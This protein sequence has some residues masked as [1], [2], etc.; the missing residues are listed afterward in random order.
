[1]SNFVKSSIPSNRFNHYHVL[2][3]TSFGVFP[4]EVGQDVEGAVEWIDDT[5]FQCEEGFAV[6]AVS[7]YTLA[8]LTTKEW[9]RINL[10]SACIEGKSPAYVGDFSDEVWDRLAAQLIP[11]YL[12]MPETKEVEAVV[13][14]ASYQHW[15]DRDA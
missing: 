3:V 6:R 7:R 10:H 15:N 2:L 4:I 1:M 13:E 5:H 11:G 14:S 9:V 12:E 8:N